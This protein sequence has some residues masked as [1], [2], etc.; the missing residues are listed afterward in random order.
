MA[1]T[2]SA[3]P[4]GGNG[5]GASALDDLTDVNATG[6]INGDLLRFD[7]SIWGTTGYSFFQRAMLP[8]RGALLE[9]TSNLNI[10]TNSYLPIPWQS[11][12]YD[13]DAFWDVA[14]PTR[15]IVPKGLTRIR[16]IANIEWQS[17]PS[18]LLLEIRKN[19]SGV[20]GGGSVIIRGKAATAIRCATSPVLCCL[21]SP[22]TGLSL[23]ST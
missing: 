18:A 20:L 7:G 21:S 17:S 6:A 2:C 4:G 23:R 9:H 11:L 1:S 16:F 12:G 8:F 14:Q 22:A 10:S 5:G 15:L 3:S 19:G 13:T